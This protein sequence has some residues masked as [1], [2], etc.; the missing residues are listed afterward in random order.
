MIRKF[1]RWLLK[2]TV[3][4]GLRTIEPSPLAGLTR[5]QRMTALALL[6]AN[7]GRRLTR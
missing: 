3:L 2:P 5:D 1:L 6:H 4:D 7:P